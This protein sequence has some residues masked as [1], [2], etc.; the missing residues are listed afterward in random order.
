MQNEI[1]REP[2]TALDFFNLNPRGNVT[3]SPIDWADQ[4]LYFFL[5]DRFSDGREQARPMFDR[6]HAETFR[7]DNVHAWMKAG[8][9][10]QGG[11]L[12]IGRARNY[13]AGIRLTEDSLVAG[14]AGRRP[15]SKHAVTLGN[16]CRILN[17]MRRFLARPA[18][19]LLSAIGSSGP[20]PRV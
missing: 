2:P 4:V 1:E 15:A 19:V 13:D 3:P 10:F 18:G 17:S 7:V 11:T 14:W 20:A 9:T 5:P 6:G 12:R 16:Y 8:A